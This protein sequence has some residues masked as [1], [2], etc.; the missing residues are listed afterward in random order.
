MSKEL[1]IIVVGAGVSGLS[2]A[3]LLA[4]S[5]YAADLRIR[6]VDA[7]KRPRWQADND[8]ALRVSAISCGSADLLQDVGA[9]SAIES[10]RLCPY[11]HMCV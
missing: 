1:E 9:W 11:D 10:S 3:A 2:V 6:V 5:Q 8:V 7:A 4:Q